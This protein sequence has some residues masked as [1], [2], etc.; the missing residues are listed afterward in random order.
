MSDSSHNSAS[1]KLDRSQA[2]PEVS[3]VSS[4]DEGI[5]VKSGYRWAIILLCFLVMVTSFVV[6]VAWASSAT[7]VGGELALSP[8]M[9]GSFVTA[10]Y[11]G[12]VL[13]NALSGFAA[14]RLGAKNVMCLALLPL[15]FFVGAFGSI[16]S[17]VQG[18]AIQCCMG[19]MA[20]V[21]FA[22]TT[23]MAAAWFVPA[24]RGRAFGILASAS[25]ISL[26][27]AN[28]LFPP[29]IEAFG[30]RALYRTMAVAVLLVA[31]ICFFLMREAP[32]SKGH[33]HD[34]SDN[35]PI[36]PTMRNLLRDRDYVFL[37]LA[38]FA[39]LWGTWGVTFWANALMVKGH[40]LSNVAA[41]QIS[42]LFGMG[43][44][45]SKPVYGFLSDLVRV[46]R[47]MMLFPCFLLFA[48]MLIVFGLATTE[49]QFRIIAPIL[50]VF[51]FIYSPLTQAMLTEI[52]GVRKVGAAS[53][54]MNAIS[55]FGSIFSPMVVGFVFQITGSFLAAFVTL[56]IGPLLAAGC[57]LMIREPMRTRPLETP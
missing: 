6:R 5:P 38:W 26:V 8:T 56:A 1:G 39:A 36:L 54:F 4:R 34:T 50:G 41:G 51:A 55:Q 29:F 25:S 57:I 49:E 52:I 42:A 14:D 15:G 10:F 20:G 19:L 24:E 43:G 23:K 35:E 28:S 11:V 40:G 18:L 27:V 37:G 53:G 9:L 2:R 12:Y 47:K 45:V 7:S 33:V 22:A 46:R 30:W 31:A 13:T 17:L 32:G 16:E 3:T 48:G 21:N 44:L